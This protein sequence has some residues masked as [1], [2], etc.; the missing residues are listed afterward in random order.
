MSAY[1]RVLMTLKNLVETSLKRV[2]GRFYIN[3][4]GVVKKVYGGQCF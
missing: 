2:F 3:L 4:L 1:K